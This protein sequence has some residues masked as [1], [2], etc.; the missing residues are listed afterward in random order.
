MNLLTLL[1]SRSA[2]LDQAR[3]A[4][5]AY[6]YATLVRMA[7]VVQRARLTGLVRLCQVD[8]KEDRYWPTLEAVSGTQ[9]SVLDEHFG[10]DDLTALA[11]AVSFAT[12]LS[13]LEVTFP[14][15]NLER[16]FADGLRA[17]LEKA[18]VKFAERDDRLFGT[19]SEV[20]SSESGDSH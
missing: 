17:E 15:E 2:L 7:A 14:I 9:Q 3:L 13:D 1:A 19:T 4:N 6:A 12:G 11:D 20:S 8:P 5:T 18:G 16:Q 10:D